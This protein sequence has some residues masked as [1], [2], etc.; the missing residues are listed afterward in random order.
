MKISQIR[1]D[2]RGIELTGKI[3]SIGDVR[4][5]Q[6]RYGPARV[7][8][9]TLKDETGSIVLNLWRDQVDLVRIGDTVRIRN[10]F[11]RTFRDRM[12][13]NVGRDGSITVLERSE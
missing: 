9:A 2:S 3:I 8:Q 10:A 1:P 5:V 11:V 4:N 12:E 7:A 6:T 13:L